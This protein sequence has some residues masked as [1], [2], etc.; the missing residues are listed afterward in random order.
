M[1]PLSF[2]GVTRAVDLEPTTAQ[3][4]S[5]ALEHLRGRLTQLEGASAS[6]RATMCARLGWRAQRAGHPIVWIHTLE[7]PYAPDLEVLGVDLRALTLVRVDTTRDALWAADGVM[8]TPTFALVILA[9][10]DTHGLHD[11]ALARLAGLAR[12]HRL[13]LVF[14]T[15]LR[16]RLGSFISERARVTRHDAG[17]QVHILKDRRGV[18]GPT[19]LEP[20]DEAMGL[21]LHPRARAAGVGGA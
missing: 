16:L 14:S 17:L 20:C 7:A 21:C 6:A 18:C 15:P 12:R 3:A 9:I 4:P 19:S 11:A 2:P 10:Q 8:R 1:R 5:L 13:G